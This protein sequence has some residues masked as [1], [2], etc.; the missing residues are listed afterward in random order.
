MLDEVELKTYAYS[1]ILAPICENFIQEKRAVGYLYNSEAKK[2]SQFSRFTLDYDYP[3]NTLPKELVQAWIAKKPTDSGRNQYARFSLICQFA[4][5]M[6]R[7]GYPAY[8][9]AA[10]EVGRYRKN[11]VP[12]IFS[13][14]EI[15]A[16]FQAA[17]SMTRLRY[18]VAPR[19][20]LIMPVL[21]RMLY[22][23]GLRVNEALKL[24]GEDVDLQQGILTIRNSKNGKTRY[25][26]M[27]AELTK[28][29]V[30]YD[31]TRLV[32]VPGN[33]WFFAAPD[34]GRYDIRAIYETFRTLLWKAGISHGGRGKGPRLHD[35]RHTFC[36]HSLERWVASG[37][38]PSAFIPRLT[39]YLG[40]ANLS[41]TEKYLRMTAEVY[42]EVSR[43]MQDNYGYIIPRME[44]SN[45]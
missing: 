7:I 1:G 44:G 39:A 17:D 38:D 32:G 30:D 8:I 42:P 34:G 6:Q 23:C 15:Q 19:R 40:H 33:D 20:H 3:P 41:C 4:Q 43:I 35:F 22:C 5:Y 37:S 26:P 27:S 9:P 21:F 10:S 14:E 24:K 18:S 11:Y 13:H 36:V 12:Y 25:V 29:C 2:L 45:L 28:V 16:F 31:K